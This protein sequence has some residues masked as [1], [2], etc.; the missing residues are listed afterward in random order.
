MNDRDIRRYDRAKRVVTFGQINDADFAPDSLVRGHFAAITTKIADTDLAKAGQTPDRVS[1]ETLLDAVM[2]DLQRIA[3]TARSIEKKSGETG[4]A[5]AYT[6]PERTE[7]TIAT[8]ADKVL[9]LLED[10]TH[11]TAAEKTAKAALRARFVEY[12]LAQ[13]FIQRLRDDR[14]AIDDA[15]AHNQTEVQD[16]VENTALI[17]KLLGEINDEVDFLDTIMGNKYERQPEKLRAWDSASRV[18]RAPVR[19]KKEKP[20]SVAPPAPLPRPSA[21]RVLQPA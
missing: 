12:E 9:G 20:A 4:F 16:G 21:P 19:S 3:A 17:G 14:D 5:A 11:D 6:V 15:N 13:T 10:Q 2:L 7:I 8:Q 1:K 18:E